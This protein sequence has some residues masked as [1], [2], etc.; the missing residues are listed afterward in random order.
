MHKT[1][2][3]SLEKGLM[4]KREELLHTLNRTH[5]DS[6]D[7]QDFGGD[8]A[9]Q[10]A[11]SQSKELTFLQQAQERKLLNLVEAALSRIGDHTFGECR[12]CG[13]EISAKRL[14]AVPWSPYCITCQEL[15]A[16]QS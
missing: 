2:T 3:T 6:Q 13:Q 4:S 7:V 10:A 1:Q 5:Q 15:V 9:D 12:S 14:K 8:E 16:E 11:A